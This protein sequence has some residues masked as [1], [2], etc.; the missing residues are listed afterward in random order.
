MK[1]LPTAAAVRTACGSSSAPTY[2][3]AAR[4]VGLT[5][6]PT[7]ERARIAAKSSVFWPVGGPP[8]EPEPAP[9]EPAPAEPKP[10]EPVPEELPPEELKPEDVDE[11]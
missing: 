5:T 3:T 1:I 9:V 11:L 6:S 8:A 4:R 10:E 2:R 7:T